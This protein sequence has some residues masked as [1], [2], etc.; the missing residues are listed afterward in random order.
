M[1]PHTFVQPEQPRGELA[2]VACISAAPSAET[3]SSTSP[4][5]LMVPLEV[6]SVRKF[7]A[8]IIRHNAVLLRCS[9][10]S[11]SARC[12]SAFSADQTTGRVRW[13]A[14]TTCSTP[15]PF[16]DPWPLK[17]PRARPDVAPPPP[18]IVSAP[19]PP[20]LRCLTAHS[21]SRPST[22]CPRLCRPT[23]APA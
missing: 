20:N 22:Q 15:I 19:S 7:S 18:P 8:A 23:P 3:A 12:S 10:H 16:S 17:E 6:R 5:L 9:Q 1:S 13:S 21:A 2:Y 11:P 4:M 14:S